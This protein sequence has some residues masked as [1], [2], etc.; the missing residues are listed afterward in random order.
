[1]WIKPNNNGFQV[2]NTFHSFAKVEEAIRQSLKNLGLDYL[3]LY[4]IHWPLGYQVNQF[5][6]PFIIPAETNASQLYEQENTE[7]FPKDADG[8]FIYSDLDYLETWKGLEHCAKLGLTKS[9]GVSNFNSVQLQR[10]LDNA[11]VKPVVN[12]VLVQYLMTRVFHILMNI[13]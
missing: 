9:I 7:L 1:M 13:L 2:W 4:L 11:T 8:K 10:I 3:D 5:S 6:L 12:Q